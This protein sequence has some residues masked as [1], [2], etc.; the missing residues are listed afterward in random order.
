MLETGS[1]RP[2]AVKG[3]RFCA[4]KRTLDGEDRSG[5]AVKRRKGAPDHDCVSMPVVEHSGAVVVQEFLK[6]LWSSCYRCPNG[7][8]HD[9][10]RGSL[11]FMR[12][13]YAQDVKRATGV[14]WS[15][16][17]CVFPPS[18]VVRSKLCK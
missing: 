9:W 6:T 4:A 12:G 8:S 16:F 11:T 17:N 2:G 14:F 5:I 13:H 15:K 3:A 1:E 18:S 7:T 10:T